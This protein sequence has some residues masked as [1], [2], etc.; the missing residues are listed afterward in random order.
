M[1]KSEILQHLADGATLEGPLWTE[2]VKVLT[3]KGL[4]QGTLKRQS[5]ILGETI[6]YA[7]QGQLAG[8]ARQRCAAVVHRRGER[9]LGREP[10]GQPAALLLHPF[11]GRV[12]A[13]QLRGV[14]GP[15][16]RADLEEPAL[17]VRGR[18]V[19]GGRVRGHHLAVHRREQA[20]LLAA[21]LEGHGPRAL[22]HAAAGLRKPDHVHGADHPVA[23]ALAGAISAGQLPKQA[24]HD[25]I[26]TDKWKWFL[27]ET[28]EVRKMTYGYRKKV[29]SDDDDRSHS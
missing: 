6:D 3:A 12:A 10:H 24:L 8:H 4:E 29:L 2:P 25:L 19:A 27:A 9:H 22:L 16:R 18:A 13:E 26:E 21:G 23:Q 15:P 17:A 1:T 14:A 11:P 28:I 5:E 20:D 7:R